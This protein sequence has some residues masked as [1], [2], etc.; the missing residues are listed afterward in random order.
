[1]HI[2]IQYILFICIKYLIDIKYNIIYNHHKQDNMKKRKRY[3]REEKNLIINK[4]RSDM[5]RTVRA[6]R[7]VYVV[8]S[9]VQNNARNIDCRCNEL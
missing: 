5:K 3:D 2:Y 8:R 4:G 9:Y 7:T 6:N 1:M